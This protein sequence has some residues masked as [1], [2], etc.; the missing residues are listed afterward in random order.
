MKKLS[1]V[2]QRG[3]SEPIFLLFGLVG[4]GFLALLVGVLHDATKQRVLNSC[5]QYSRVEIRG[6]MYECQ[7]FVKLNPKIKQE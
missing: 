1:S 7:P 5:N 2:N 4:A 3:G 6:V